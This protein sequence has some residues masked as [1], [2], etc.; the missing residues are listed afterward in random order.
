MAVRS[1]RAHL[2]HPSF[3]RATRPKT[4]PDDRRRLWLF[5]YLIDRQT[6]RV[7]ENGHGK[8]SGG[9]PIRD[10]DIA[11]T[12][13][14]SRRTIIRWREILGRHGYIT[15]RRTPYGHVYAIAKP[16]KWKK[17][18]PGSSETDVTKMAHLSE[19]NNSRD[20]QVP[21][22]RCAGSCTNKEDIT[23]EY[24]RERRQETS[25]LAFLDPEMEKRIWGAYLSEVKPES[26]YSLTPSRK[27]MLAARYREQIADGQTPLEAATNLAAAIFAISADDYHM[28]RKKGYEGRF[29]N[30]FEDIFGT[31]EVFEKWCST[32]QASEKAARV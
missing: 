17:E 10:K 7:D 4:L 15:A 16:K 9:M 23:R 13:G 29:R 3:E 30:E 11:S 32:Y 14:S 8:V 26:N 25:A 21:V 1:E 12:L 22:K 28:G 5:I 6:R 20:V 18:S 2:H 19:G 24:K 27:E 31:R